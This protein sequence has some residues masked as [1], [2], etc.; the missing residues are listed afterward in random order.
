M[1]IF[2]ISKLLGP[3]M[4]K[5]NKRK[6]D[7]RGAMLIVAAVLIPFFLFLTLSAIDFGFLL[8]NRFMTVNALAGLV[9]DLKDNPAGFN[10]A[11]YSQEAGL[12]WL[13]FKVSGSP[14]AES[15][16]V[17]TAHSTRDDAEASVKGHSCK[18]T[19]VT[20]FS[21][22]KPFIASTAIHLYR[23]FSPLALTATDLKNLGSL[24]K[25]VRFSQVTEI[26]Q[27]GLLDSENGYFTGALAD[28]TTDYVAWSKF[29]RVEQPAVVTLTCNSS[30][31]WNNHYNGCSKT[32]TAGWM[33]TA[34]INDSYCS[35]DNSWSVLVSG[36]TFN[37]STTCVQHLGP[38]SHKLSCIG[39]NYGDG[40]ACSPISTKNLGTAHHQ[41]GYTVFAR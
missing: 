28:N 5:Q 17:V 26:K 13:K 29:V 10:L 36:A 19:S 32:G 1:P 9:R 2:R 12:G 35:S 11:Q 30:G 31:F 14:G 37:T 7:E 24:T 40:G 3:T 41:Y 23:Y 4:L 22:A 20:S 34:L 39:Q 8:S 6:A 15:C 21:Q 25:E 18:T 16:L 27:R 38:G 33:I